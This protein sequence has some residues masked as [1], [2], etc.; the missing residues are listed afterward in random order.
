MLSAY[1]TIEDIKN[2]KFIWSYCTYCGRKITK[3]LLYT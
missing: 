3:L 1:K 2:I